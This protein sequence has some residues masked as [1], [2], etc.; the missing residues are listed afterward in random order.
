[1]DSKLCYER[2]QHQKST[3]QQ[4]RGEDPELGNHGSNQQDADSTTEMANPI[5][6]REAR[7]TGARRIVF[8][9]PTVGD[10]NPEI[11]TEENDDGA[12]HTCPHHVACLR[13]DHA[14]YQ[15]YDRRNRE[16]GLAFEPLAIDISKGRTEREAESARRRD[17]SCLG[18]R[19]FECRQQGR[20][21]CR[22]RI[23][24]DVAHEPHGGQED[25][26]T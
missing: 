24:G 7:R 26:A 15:R 16:P 21:S 8:G 19:I 9:G 4:H 11:E 23:D 22:E 2:A 5:R 6:K 10:W 18:G 17:Q 12:E 20:K 13:D 25:G 14:T 3:N 1:V